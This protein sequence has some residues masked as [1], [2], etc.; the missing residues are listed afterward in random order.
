MIP[1]E[2]MN[3]GSDAEQRGGLPTGGV[4]DPR[5]V[6][7]DVMA[8]VEQTLRVRGSCSLD[9]T[10]QRDFGLDGD[11]AEEFLQKF[12][13]RFEVDLS[14]FRFQQHFGGEGFGLTYRHVAILTPLVAASA[15]WQLS[16]LHGTLAG[17][18]GISLLWVF[19]SRL[20]SPLIALRVED[21]VRAATSR[22]WAFEY[23]TIES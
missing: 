6:Q 13:G 11:D 18:L 3:D 17:V 7:A 22:R 4:T 14:E 9:S 12:A 21:L 10:L 15:F 2:P 23:A 16:W 1:L 5:R 20:R 19:R 8:W